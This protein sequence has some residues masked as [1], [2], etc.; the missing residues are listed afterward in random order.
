LSAIG[1]G[2]FEVQSSRFAAPRAFGAKVHSTRRGKG[3]SGVP[4]LIFH[5]QEAGRLFHFIGRKMGAKKWEQAFFLPV[6][7]PVLD[8]WQVFYHGRA[9]EFFI[10]LYSLIFTCTDLYQPQPGWAELQQAAGPSAF[11]E[12]AFAAC[13]CAVK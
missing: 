2:G 9:P 8:E 13:P 7:L 11:F 10:W 4:P 6:A 1:N 12:P 3:G 5:S